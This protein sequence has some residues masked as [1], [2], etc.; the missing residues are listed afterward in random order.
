MKSKENIQDSEKTNKGIDYQVKYDFLTN[1]LNRR[2][3]IN[4][5]NTI[6]SQCNMGEDLH[7]YLFL[8]VDKF[9]NINDRFGHD[10]GDKLLISLVERIKPL[11]HEDDILARMSGDEFAIILKNINQNS[12]DGMRRINEVCAKITSELSRPFRLNQYEIFTGVSIGVRLFPDTDI[13]KV[14]DIIIQSD[15]AMYRSKHKKGSVTIYDETIAQEFK[16]TTLLK[17]DLEKAYINKEYVFYFQ[18]KVEVQTNKIKGVEILVRWQHPKRGWLLPSEFFKEALKIGM[19]SKITDLSI[20]EACEFIASTKEYYKGTISI[21]VSSREIE[22]TFFISRLVSTIQEYGIE[23]NRIE[24]E[25]TE[26]ELIQNFDLAVILIKQLQ[27]LG[28]AVSMDDFGTGYSS[29]TYLHK[30]PVDTLKIDKSF[31]E[32]LNVHHTS[33]KDLVLVKT[34]ANMAKAFNLKIIAEGVENEAQLSIVKELGIDEY[35]GFLFSEAVDKERL[36]EL[37]KHN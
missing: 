5:L 13:E 11:L 8:D 20:H 3:L 36:L 12:S 9:K 24:L 34:I 33:D 10:T 30:L 4:A 32:N 25:I 15:V 22:D 23:A 31:I 17:E 6:Y 1:V 29:I 16:D 18:P 19:V 37:V 35:Q 2:S 7:A 21:N 28:I 14:S 27:E 26:E